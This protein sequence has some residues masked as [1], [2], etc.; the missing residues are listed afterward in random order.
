MG[1]KDNE[2]SRFISATEWLEKQDESSRAY[3][4]PRKPTIKEMQK[5][6]T[7]METW[8]FR[9]ALQ[10]INKARTL[11][12]RKTLTPKQKE[13][14]V[15]EATGKTLQ[16]LNV[17]SRGDLQ[18]QYKDVIKQYSTRGSG[19]IED[20]YWYTNVMGWVGLDKDYQ[21]RLIKLQD[22]LTPAELDMLYDEL[23]ELTL[24]YQNTKPGSHEQTTVDNNIEEWQK[25][26]DKILK[27][28][29]NIVSQRENQDNNEDNNEDNKEE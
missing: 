10:R 13:R 8:E 12:K 24:Y 26:L 11:Y 23:P 21:D 6:K 19:H 3:Y 29:E 1:K 4:H 28:Y 16:E 27:Y 14:I 22:E 2:P 18:A 25:K 7:T 17:Q 15:T 9:Y 20:V 5:W